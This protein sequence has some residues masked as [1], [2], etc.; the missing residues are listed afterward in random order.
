MNSN[1]PSNCFLISPVTV[2][3]FWEKIEQLERSQALPSLI[4]DLEDAVSPKDRED[5]RKKLEGKISLV[6]V[7]NAHETR[8]VFLRINKIGTMESHEDICL[9]KRIHDADCKIGVVIPKVDSPKDLETFVSELGFTPSSLFVAIESLA[10]YKNTE[11]ILSFPGIEYATVGL[12]DLTAEM[13]CCRPLNFYR[14]EI[15]REIVVDV[16]LKAMLHHIKSIAPLWPFMNYPELLP[17][18]IDE[19]VCGLSC[20]MAGMVLFHP[21]QIE[22]ANFFWSN[23]TLIE[24]YKKA[25]TYRKSCLSDHII[26]T[27]SACSVFDFKMIDLPELKRR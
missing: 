2:D 25:V 19:I 12:E 20:H 15:L 24:G 10:G 14:D 6:S 1:M 22:Y 5:G 16:S 23:K 27:S 11:A 13:G 7:L 18:Y 8:K 4:L 21:Y 3:K 9:L 17:S 26:R